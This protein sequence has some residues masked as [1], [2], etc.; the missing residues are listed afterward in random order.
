MGHFYCPISR[1][2]LWLRRR[3]SRPFSRSLTA[4]EPILEGRAT[5]N[6]PEYR[7]KLVVALELKP[8][9]H[10]V[11]PRFMH[12]REQCLAVMVSQCCRAESLLEC[13]V[14]LFQLP[15]RGKFVAFEKIAVHPLEVM[16]QAR[17]QIKRVCYL[18]GFLV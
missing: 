14:V 4:I 3:S 10:R 5:R 1:D 18:H 11:G 9:Y 17:M 8:I 12:E 7:W 13:P 6:T 16:Q 2:Y 15:P